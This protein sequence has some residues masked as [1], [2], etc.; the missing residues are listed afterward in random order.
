MHW[1]Q[2]PRHSVTS[3][4]P[5]CGPQVI[6]YPRCLLESLL[7][8]R[9]GAC[10]FCATAVFPL[11]AC[12]ACPRGCLAVFLYTFLCL[13]ATTT[14]AMLPELPLSELDS[15]DVEDVPPL[16]ELFVDELSVSDPCDSSD[17]RRSGRQ[18]SSASLAVAVSNKYLT[19][20]R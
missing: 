15:D 14:L 12:S 9:F 11:F 6:V 2:A 18:S 8:F 13:V 7:N 10:R 4:A 20:V 5:A 17:L 1:S 3:Y 19:A 16:L